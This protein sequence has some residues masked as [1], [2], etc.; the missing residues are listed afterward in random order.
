M[1]RRATT[2]RKP[3]P[4]M[5][6]SLIVGCTQENADNYNPTS[7]TDDGSCLIPVDG[8]SN[9][10]GIY[11]LCTDNNVDTVI[12]YCPDES[13]NAIQMYILSGALENLADYLYVYDGADT[14]RR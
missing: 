9:V 5:D 14:T 12:T 6:V 10:S 11:S 3:R 13:E 2:N 4:Y 8:C 1:R 7:T